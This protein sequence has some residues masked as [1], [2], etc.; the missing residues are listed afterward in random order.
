VAGWPASGIHPVCL[1][2]DERAKVMKKHL[3]QHGIAFRPLLC[4]DIS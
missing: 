1:I 3:A 4:S 2:D